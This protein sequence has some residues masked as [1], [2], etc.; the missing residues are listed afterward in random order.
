[1]PTHETRVRLL[2]SIKELPFFVWD[3]VLEAHFTEVKPQYLTRINVWFSEEWVEARASTFSSK[4]LEAAP[5]LEALTFYHNSEGAK[6]LSSV[7][8]L[9]QFM[10]EALQNG[11]LQRL[12]KVELGQWVLGG[13]YLADFADA[14]EGSGCAKQVVDLIFRE[15]VFSVE[16]ISVLADRLGRDAFP[17]LKTLDLAKFQYCGCRRS[18][19]RQGFTQSGTHSPN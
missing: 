8:P 19:P 12:K 7:A 9:L 16:A 4:V 13:D 5:V 10:T 1:M 6:P 3:H 2:P 14:L 11:A 18:F 15:C 17:S